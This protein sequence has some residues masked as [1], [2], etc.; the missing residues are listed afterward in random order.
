[1]ATRPNKGND[2]D[3]VNY[4]A[5]WANAMKVVEERKRKEKEEEKKRKEEEEE[6]KRKAFEEVVQLA[7]DLAKKK[8]EEDERKKKKEEEERKKK[9]EKEEEERKRQKEK[10]EEERKRQK[11]KEE[12]ERKM[13]ANAR[14]PCADQEERPRKAFRTSEAYGKEVPICWC[15]TDCTV[16][17]S[18]DYL[19]DSWGKKFFMCANY[20]RSP[21]RSRNPYD[22]PRVCSKL[23]SSSCVPNYSIAYPLTCTIFL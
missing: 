19:S 10:E 13:R 12:E 7:R 23:F 2:G 8:D 3:G 18:Q 1:M 4:S 15:G 6:K 9:R 22:K 14:P 11:E 17:E 5:I 21:E 16:K 20:N